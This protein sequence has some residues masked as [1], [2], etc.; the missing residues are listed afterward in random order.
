MGLFGS[1]KEK[2]LRRE[3]KYQE[4]MRQIAIA[5]GRLDENRLEVLDLGKDAVKVGDE[6]LINLAAAGLKRID[7]SKIQLKKARAVIGLMHAQGIT[8][9]TLAPF[10]KVVK[11]V[12]ELAESMGIAEAARAKEEIEKASQKMESFDVVYNTALRAISTKTIK[13]PDLE[14]Y[15]QEL[16]AKAM[17]EEEKKIPHEI[18][19]ANKGIEEVKKAVTTG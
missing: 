18:V 9:R 10:F 12:S 8:A 4:I 14:P 5:E 15:I 7:E 6:N 1:K 2:E 17:I 16:K 11:D 3:L 13:T 19:E